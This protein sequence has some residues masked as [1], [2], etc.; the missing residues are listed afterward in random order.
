MRILVSG[1]GGHM[2]AEV[3]KLCRAG[4]RGAEL[5][6]GVDAM[7]WQSITDVPCAPDFSGACTD[8]DCVVG[9]SHDACTKAVL[10]L[11]MRSLIALG[12]ATAGQSD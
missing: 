8:V 10:D 7:N 6:A 4:C 12:L 11:G 1:L 3:A 5:A 2:G 9:C